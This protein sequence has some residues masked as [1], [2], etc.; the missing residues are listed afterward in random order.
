VY[1]V[2]EP[3]EVATRVAGGAL[4]RDDRKVVPAKEFG[5][6]EDEDENRGPQGNLVAVQDLFAIAV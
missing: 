6:A 5:V 3:A 1:Y 4:A 2:H